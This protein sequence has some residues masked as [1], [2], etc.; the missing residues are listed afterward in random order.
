MENNLLGLMM[1]ANVCIFILSLVLT[2]CI[3]DH[4]QSSVDYSSAS[5]AALCAALGSVKAKHDEYQFKRLQDLVSARIEANT[6]SI[7][8]EQCQDLAIKGMIATSLNEELSKANCADV[9]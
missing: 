8:A 7:S 3:A 9:A 2:G 4:S 5:P 6:F 1:K